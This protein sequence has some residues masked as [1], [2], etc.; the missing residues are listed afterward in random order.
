MIQ[1]QL[2]DI[3]KVNIRTVN[4]HIKNIFDSDELSKSAT[5]RKFRIV[6]TEGK[7]KVERE[8]NHYNLDITLAV[9]YRVNSAKATNL[10]IYYFQSNYMKNNKY[11]RNKLFTAK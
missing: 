1:K 9:G 4:E 6:Q 7:R 8:V 11:Y 2:A 5:I 3:F 10:Y